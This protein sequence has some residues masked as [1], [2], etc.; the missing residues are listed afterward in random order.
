MANIECLLETG[1]IL[2]MWLNFPNNPYEVDSV[3]ILPENLFV[4]LLCAKHRSRHPVG[5]EYLPTCI[6]WLIIMHLAMWL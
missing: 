2:S 6:S 3:F 5:A 4:C 1:T